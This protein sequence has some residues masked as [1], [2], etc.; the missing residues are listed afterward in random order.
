MNDFL[1]ICGGTSML[2]LGL[3]GI[4]SLFSVLTALLEKK[5][6]RLWSMLAIAVVIAV[7][8]IAYI[9]TSQD[10]NYLLRNVIC[11][12]GA[13]L[14]FVLAI[15]DTQQ[16]EQQQRIDQLG[17]SSGSEGSK[18]DFAIEKDIPQL[19]NNLIKLYDSSPKGNGW[20]FEHPDVVAIGE[21][22]N[23]I[24]GM[25]AMREAHAMF[26]QRR[27]GVARNLEHIWD[28]IGSWQG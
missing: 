14:I 22:L 10:E 3:G 11:I 16:K 25:E 4:I 12:V 13:I 2:V 5:R 8:V 17:S 19:V 7:I 24:G 21:K 27:P 26:A 1:S 15:F 9:F 18:I 6:P 28:G 23:E 20:G